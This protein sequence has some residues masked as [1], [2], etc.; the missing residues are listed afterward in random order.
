MI[1]RL[2]SIKSSGSNS[3]NVFL[4]LGLP[5]L[6]AVFWKKAENSGMS[7]ILELRLFWGLL[8]YLGA[9]D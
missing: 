6:L 4:G 9:I 5:W 1:V 7:D 8:F 3:V 2:I